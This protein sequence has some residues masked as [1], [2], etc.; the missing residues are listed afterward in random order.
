VYARAHSLLTR[1]PPPTSVR[2]SQK[3]VLCRHTTHRSFGG[4][5]RSAGRRHW[6][7]DEVVICGSAPLTRLSDLAG[8]APLASFLTSLPRSSPSSRREYSV[9]IG[10]GDARHL[11]AHLSCSCVRYLTDFT[12]VFRKKCCVFHRLATTVI[13]FLNIGHYLRIPMHVSTR[14]HKPAQPAVAKCAMTTCC[15]LPLST[16][17][18]DDTQACA[19]AHAINSMIYLCF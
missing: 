4:G 15:A 7:L 2:K 14:V 13:V 10:D 12:Y 5:C 11:H 19:R 1:V 9:T 16:H 18:H 6:V 3:R 8:G 17:D